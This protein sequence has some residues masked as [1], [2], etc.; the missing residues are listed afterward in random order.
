MDIVCCVFDDMD[1]LT[2]GNMALYIDDEHILYQHMDEYRS[3]MIE[4]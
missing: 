3:V 1:C 2:G 4:E